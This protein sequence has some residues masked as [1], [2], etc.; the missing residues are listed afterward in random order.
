M[1]HLSIIHPWP[2]LCILGVT[3][4][5]SYVP[6][7]VLGSDDAGVS[8]RKTWSLASL[9]LRFSHLPLHKNLKS[10]V[11]RSLW[12]GKAWCALRTTM[13]DVSWAGQ[14]VR[15]WI[16][17]DLLAA[18]SASWLQQFCPKVAL[19]ECRR[20]KENKDLW[21]ESLWHRCVSTSA[22]RELPRAR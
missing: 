5:I 19:S 20:M 14:G 10:Q 1:I 22:H 6:D 11:Q 21:L 15:H 7:M 8:K 3:L 18:G 12:E 4:Y 9:S 16:I 2:H 13:R 17:W